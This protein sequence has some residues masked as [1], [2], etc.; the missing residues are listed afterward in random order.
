MAYIVKPPSGNTGPGIHILLIGVDKY[1]HLHDAKGTPSELGTDFDVLDAPTHSCKL[2]A[3]W[4]A[5]GNLRH[6]GLSIKSV[7]VLA[8]R[9]VGRGQGSR[10]RT[11]EPTFEN[12]RLA[13]ERW[14]DLGDQSP[15][16]LLVFYFC[17]HGLQQTVGTHS[18]LCADFGAHK[19]APYD[20]AIHYE[21]L[22]SGMRSCAAKRQIFLLDTCRT[23]SGEILNRFNGRGHDVVA[24]RAPADLGETSQSVIWATAGGAQ[25]WAREG[26]P[27]VFA[28]AFLQCLRGGAA[29][30]DVNTGTVIANAMSIRTAMA[31]Y[32]AA[33]ADI[34]QE[35]QISQPVGKAFKF[36]EFG[37]HLSIPVVVRCSPPENTPGANLSCR[38]NGGTIRKRRPL[39]NMGS[40]RWLL[41]LPQGNYTFRAVSY[42][43]SQHEG[44][45]AQATFPPLASVRIPME[46]K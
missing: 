35:P 28:Q 37:Q 39:A 2:L 26:A 21:G 46:Q 12:V 18:L 32:L 43:D 11:E 24:R 9:A 45:I 34:D 5:G 4:F 19:H 22:E 30:Q 23:V 31:Q 36:H 29:I 8:S 42:Y 10:P 6:G 38:Q 7:D 16:N 3:N 15:D 27:S 44:E 17:G 20:H 1:P 14:Y 13:I 41:E 40:D 33:V 25:A